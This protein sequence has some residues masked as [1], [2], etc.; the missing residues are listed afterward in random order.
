MGVNSEKEIYTI[1]ANAQ[2]RGPYKFRPRVGG[3]STIRVEVSG[4]WTG[5]ALLQSVSPGDAVAATTPVTKTY[6]GGT[7]DVSVVEGGGGCD[8]YVT[9]TAA[10]TGTMVITFTRGPK[11]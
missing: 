4:T 2:V 8:F 5:T 10:M 1:T 11:S 6:T 7:N 9:A 3:N